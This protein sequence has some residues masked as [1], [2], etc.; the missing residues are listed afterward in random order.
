MSTGI[1][2][3]IILKS[4]PDDPFESNVLAYM[5]VLNLFTCTGIRDISPRNPMEVMAT[6]V[7]VIVSQVVTIVLMCGF[8]SISITE[9]YVLSEY[10]FNIE[11]LYQYLK[12]LTKF[13]FILFFS[14]CIFISL[15]TPLFLFCF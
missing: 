13:P 9:N 12:V 14:I 2:P 1:Q 3:Q 4:P 5:Y 15:A 6:I 8:T 7:I 10:E 11:K